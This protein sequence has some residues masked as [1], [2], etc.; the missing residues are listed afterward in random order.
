MAAAVAAAT[1]TGGRITAYQERRAPR[2]TAKAA[3]IAD[4]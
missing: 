1:A 2:L 3:P 4:T